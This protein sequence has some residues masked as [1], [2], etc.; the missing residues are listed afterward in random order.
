MS[1]T[2][3]AQP[4]IRYCHP[5]PLEPRISKPNSGA[6]LPIHGA[7]Q[8]ISTPDDPRRR[9]R[10]FL[11][12]IPKER[13]AFDTWQHVEAELNKAAAGADTA[14]VSI[15]LQMALTLSAS[16]IGRSSTCCIHTTSSELNFIA[17]DN[18][19]LLPPGERVAAALGACSRLLLPS[20]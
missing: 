13:R 17:G 18:A 20:A 8:R 14:Q 2:L 15:A 10:D 19:F 4:L 6:P 3:G 11:K 12:H 9:V 5:P 1:Q 7:I 16:N